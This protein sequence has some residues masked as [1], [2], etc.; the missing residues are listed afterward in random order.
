MRDSGCD[1]GRSP[2]GASIPNP[3]IPALSHSAQPV[4]RPGAYF[5]LLLQLGLADGEVDHVAPR[6]HPAQ[7]VA[8]GG[9][10]LL[11]GARLVAH[12]VPARVLD[13]RVPRSRE[14]PDGV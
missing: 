14:V 1:I 4:G 3:P 5:H 6:G 10:A 7:L 9:A 8:V 13:P 11:A 12:Q 2:P